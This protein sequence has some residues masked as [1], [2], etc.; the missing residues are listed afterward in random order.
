MQAH[1]AIDDGNMAETARSPLC[2]SGGNR[3]PGLPF[4][5]GERGGAMA[6]E[7][8][9][10]CDGL[11]AGLLSLAVFEKTTP[12]GHTRPGVEPRKRFSAA[13]SPVVP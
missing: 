8:P 7:L 11:S 3:C 9:V 10:D 4:R 13:L 12:R 1:E 5:L 6:P 2:V